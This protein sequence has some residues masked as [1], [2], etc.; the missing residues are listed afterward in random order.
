MP[1]LDLT[2]D[3]KLFGFTSTTTQWAHT[4]ASGNDR[5]LI[6]F[7]SAGS[8]TSSDTQ[9]S[10][11]TYGAASLTMLTNSFIHDGWDGISIWYLVAPAVQTANI[12]ITWPVATNNVQGGIAV[13]ATDVN[14]S[15]PLGTPARA[16]GSSTSPSTGAITSAVGDLVVA[17]IAS[18][19]ASGI[20]EG[21]TL[22]SEQE[23]HEGDTSYGAESYSGAATVTATWTQAENT[24][25]AVVGVS[26]Q[27][28]TAGP[29]AGSDTSLVGV[30][31]SSANLIRVSIVEETS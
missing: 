21:G 24:G 12:T 31:E 18:D 17:G 29:G 11:V 19:S 22:I 9:P 4:T 10:G 2:N 30:S 23:N 27:Q 28:A 5:L 1:T 13:V 26:V 15:S 6:V 25:W 16:T 7:A 14:Q 3:S 20:T 8:N